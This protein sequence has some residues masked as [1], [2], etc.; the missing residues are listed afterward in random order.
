LNDFGE[1]W[2]KFEFCNV[3][4]PDEMEKMSKDMES[5]RVRV[6]VWRVRD[7]AGDIEE[8][9]AGSPSPSDEGRESVRVWNARE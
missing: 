6:H 7:V 8:N 1:G 4:D 5:V 2:E 9:I 3:K